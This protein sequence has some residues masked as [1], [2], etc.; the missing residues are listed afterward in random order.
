MMEVRPNHEGWRLSH[1][2]ILLKTWSIFG[3]FAGQFKIIGASKLGLL[4][5]AGMAFFVALGIFAPYLAPYDPYENVVYPDGEPATLEPPSLAHPF[6]TT[7]MSHDVLSQLIWGTRRTLTIALAAAFASILLGTNMGLAAG[8][9]GGKIDNILMRMT[10]VAYGIPFL[11]FAMVALMILGTQDIILIIVMASIGWR[12]SA[13][14]VRSQVLTLRERPFVSVAESLGA[15]PARILYLHIAPN[16]LP[17][18]VMNSIL[19]VGEC[20]LVEASISFLG[21]GNPKSISWGQMLFY[22]FASARMRVAWWW[23]LMPGLAIMLLVLSVFVVGRSYEEVV[24]PR[25]R[26]W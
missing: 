9:Y 16:V 25:L 5:L 12:T 17:L 2:P 1:H 14:I 22:C 19:F 6:G 26:E 23:S 8:Y 4:G 21:F 20:A 24:N 7:L 11:P 18:A 10:D 15:S 13:R 3:M